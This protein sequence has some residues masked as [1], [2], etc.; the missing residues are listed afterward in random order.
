M[1]G[2]FAGKVAVVTGA[3]KGIG[4]E[5]A[6]QLGAR[7]ASV[8]VNYS[9]SKAD[10]DKV[11]AEIT[12]SGGK[13]VVVQAN[14]SQEADIQRLFA[15]TKRAFGKLDILINNA[16]VYDFAP[17]DDITAENFHRQF[18]LNVLGL[19][20]ATREAVKLMNGGGSIVNISSVVA[21]LALPSSTV[22]AAT[23]AAVDSI[24]RTLA[25]EL[26]PRRIRVNAVNPG[27]VA[28]EGNT[29]A[30]EESE[31]RVAVEAQTPLGRIGQVDDIAPAVLFLASDD[32]KWITGEVHYI[33]GGYR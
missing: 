11:A 19:I 29:T 24:T 27:M 2:K 17:L 15:E 22:Y 12:G 3:S 7:G 14:V 8:V 13:A 21:R 30:A 26:G 20:L 32:S 1:A 28:T 4:A 10:A 16:G 6:R 5:I 9:S 33:A 23:K 18:N 25:A 31:F